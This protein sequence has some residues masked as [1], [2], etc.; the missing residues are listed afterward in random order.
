MSFAAMRPRGII[1]LLMMR[2]GNKY[3]MDGSLYVPV[4]REWREHEQRRGICSLHMWKRT[5]DLRGIS[6]FFKFKVLQ[7]SILFRVQA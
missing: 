7:F 2:P 3:D 5:C 1:S 4:R 6:I